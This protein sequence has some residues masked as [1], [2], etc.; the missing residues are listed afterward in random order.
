MERL[1]FL[2]A[3]KKEALFFA[4]ISFFFK[5]KKTRRVLDFKTKKVCLNALP[6]Q[7]LQLC[8]FDYG[9]DQ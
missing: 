6:W 1:G 4:F 3:E 7:K 5:G 8:P 2:G 9:G